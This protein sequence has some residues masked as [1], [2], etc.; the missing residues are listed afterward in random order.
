MTATEKRMG[1]RLIEKEVDPLESDKVWEGRAML[2]KFLMLIKL[3]FFFN[4]YPTAA[5]LTSPS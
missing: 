4:I 5:D 2:Y 1:E 3:G